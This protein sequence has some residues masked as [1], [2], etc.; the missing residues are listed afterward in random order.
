MK[1]IIMGTIFTIAGV[2]HFLKPEKFANIT[3][4]FLPFRTFIAYFTGVVEL[5]FGMLLL[6]GKVTNWQLGA[7]QK[8]LWAIFPANIYMYTHQ[9]KL[10]IS[11]LPD[12]ALLGRLPLQKVMSDTLEDMEKIGHSY[13]WPIFFFPRST[14]G[15]IFSG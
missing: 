9:D 14:R 12:W 11:H 5:L 8:F 13:T 7:M 1:R 2:A 6:T 3:P 15:V 4:R 10:G